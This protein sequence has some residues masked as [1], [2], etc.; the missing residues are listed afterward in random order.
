MEPKPKEPG[1]VFFLN[2]Y[3]MEV[4]IVKQG[5]PNHSD[6]KLKNLHFLIDIFFSFCY[7]PTKNYL[8]VAIRD[9]VIGTLY[10]APN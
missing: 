9:Y 5:S 7:S 3:W 6:R 1:G 4:N 2:K 10:V 8:K